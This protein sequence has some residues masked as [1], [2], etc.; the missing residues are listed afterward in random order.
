[1]HYAAKERLQ[2]YAAAQTGLVENEKNPEKV[3]KY[4][5]FIDYYADLSEQEII[6]FQ[7]QYIEKGENMGLTQILIQKGLEEGIEKGREEGREEGIEKGREEGREE[8][9]EQGLEKGRRQESIA[10]LTRLLRRKFGLQPALEPILQQLNALPVVDLEDLAE[11]LFDLTTTA[12]IA[13]WL[14]G[15][16]AN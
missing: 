5:E 11:A 12:D 6:E 16:D 7:E 3:R 8:G 13:A 1:M 4:A 14:K 9:L 10:L 15:K 2:I